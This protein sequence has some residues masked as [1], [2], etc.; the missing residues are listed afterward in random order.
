[1]NIPRSEMSS[2]PDV[3]I[4][5]PEIDV[6]RHPDFSAAKAGDADAADRLVE[7]FLMPEK[8]ASSRQLIG[9]EHPTLMPVH[10]QESDGINQ[11]PVALADKLGHLFQLEVDDSVIQANKVKHTGADGYTRVANPATFTGDVTPGK[12]YLIVDDFI[13]QGGTVANLAG[14]IRSHGGN[15]LGAVT[16]TGRDYSAKLAP[17]PALI[18]ALRNKHGSE[19]EDWWRSKFGYGFD[20]LT[21]SEA[22][23]LER[24][25]DADTI[26]A[27]IAA[28][29]QKRHP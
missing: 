14:Y 24:S 26:R 12:N 13:G 18:D 25:G 27:R 28:A 1:M 22:R 20:Q 23:Y 11:I 9:N 3:R 16:L 15:V 17:D 2:M 4:L 7:D 10:A 29:K 8:L 5:A 19:L 6:K 21:Q